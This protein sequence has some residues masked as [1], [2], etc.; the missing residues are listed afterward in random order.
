MDDTPCIARAAHSS[1]RYC[2]R[3]CNLSTPVL[4]FSWRWDKHI[5]TIC[6]PRTR[7]GASVLWRAFQ[8]PRRVFPAGEHPCALRAAGLAAHHTPPLHAS[9]CLA[10]AHSHCFDSMVSRQ[11]LYRHATEHW[12]PA[13]PHTPRCAAPPSPAVDRWLL[14]HIPLRAP[15]HACVLAMHLQKRQSKA[16]AARALAPRARSLARL[17]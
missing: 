5:A 14:S 10:I 9:L 2:T 4:C 13:A 15:P 8:A 6:C 11:R 3:P 1:V 17:V 16:A 12:R 7:A